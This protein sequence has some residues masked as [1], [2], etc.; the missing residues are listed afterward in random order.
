[1]MFPLLTPFRCL[2]FEFVSLIRTR[3]SLG[4][5]PKVVKRLMATLDFPIPDLH[6]V[7]RPLCISLSLVCTYSQLPRLSP[8]ISI[9][10]MVM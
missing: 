10:G 9:A 1:M 3:Y 6:Q 4:G 7:H 5:R 8:T 2:L